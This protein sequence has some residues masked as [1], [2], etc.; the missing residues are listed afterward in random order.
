M[1]K[2]IISASTRT[3]LYFWRFC[4]NI[5]YFKK[6]NN[7][8]MFPSSVDNHVLP[9][10][11]CKHGYCIRQMICMIVLGGWRNSHCDFPKGFVCEREAGG[12]T[13]P[14]TDKPTDSVSGFCPEGYFGMGKTF[15]Y[16]N[17]RNMLINS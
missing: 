3:I 12:S 6:A 11:T 13:N 2:I 10:K 7:Y 15:F 9:D 16:I 1:L 14:I 8:V 4:H 17:N 5:I